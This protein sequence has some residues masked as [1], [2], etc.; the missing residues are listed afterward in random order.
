MSDRPRLVTP[1]FLLVTFSN[2]FYF[3]SV[4]ALIPVLPLYVQETLGGGDIAVGVVIG[5]FALAAVLLRPVSGRISDQRG[6]R[7]L[8]LL[9]SAMVVASVIGY[10]FT[11]SLI[12]LL[13]LRLVTGA[14]EA[15]F[16]VGVASAINDI[17]P[18]ERR[19]EALSY[20]SLAL[21]GGLAI[22]PIIGETVLGAGRFHLTW[23]VSAGAASIAFLLGLKV[24]DTR[25]PAIQP[26][27]TRRIVHPAAIMP[28]TVLAASIWGLSGFTTFVPLYALS[29]GLGGSRIVFALYSSIVMLIRS[30]GAKIPDKLGVRKTARSA[31]TSSAIGL[32]VMALWPGAPGLYV[33]T[34]LFAVGQA[35]AFPAL[36]A[37]AVTSAPA[38][39][40]GSVIGTFT[41]FFD[42]AFGLGAVSLGA[43]ASALDYQ[44][45]F[46]VAS[47]VSAGG[48][49]LLFAYARK[50]DR[51]A[52]TS[53]LEAGPAPG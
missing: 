15:F 49:V 22:G 30:V 13:L 24:P 52:A 5:T 11:S 37:I 8:I 44:G 39:E 18:D 40:R 32:A 23:F 48:I 9:G 36:M 51:A 29:I 17:S 21:Y 27:G 26:S 33:G 19:G 3:L 7:V 41:A 4:G 38:N 14:G 46:G 35:L 42:L 12:P 20:F 43:V 28:G 45:A 2:F 25:D 16:Y 50:G 34:V 31:L 1:V 10:A 53:E 47:I 6:R